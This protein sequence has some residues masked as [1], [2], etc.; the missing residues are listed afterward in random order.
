MARD[1]VQNLPL[2]LV[3]ASIGTKSSGGAGGFAGRQVLEGSGGAS[4]DL[5]GLKDQKGRKHLQSKVSL[6]KVGRNGSGDI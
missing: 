1:M 3:L 6:I 2:E 5:K 4:K